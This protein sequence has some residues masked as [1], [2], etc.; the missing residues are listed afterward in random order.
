MHINV[1]HLNVDQYDIF[2]K[3]IPMW[4]IQ[5]YASVTYLDIGQHNI[6][7]LQQ[8][9]RIEG[10]ETPVLI[11]DATFHSDSSSPIRLLSYQL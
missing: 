5:M 11:F 10:G 7:K 1:A 8:G 6:F 3:C 9:V 4:H 2:Y